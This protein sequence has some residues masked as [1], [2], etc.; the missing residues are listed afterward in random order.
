MD[1]YKDIGRDVGNTHLVLSAIRRYWETEASRGRDLIVAQQEDL[2]QLA[3]NS[4]GILETIQEVLDKH[5]SLGNRGRVRDKLKWTLASFVKDIG[6]QRQSLQENTHALAIFN[7]T[8]TAEN[9]SGVADQQIKV[10]EEHSQL[11]K[12]LVTRYFEYQTGVDNR[13]T[14]TFSQ[15]TVKDIQDDEDYSWQNLYPEFSAAGFDTTIVKRNRGFIREWITTVIPDENEKDTI[16]IAGSTIAE[17]DDDH[18]LA[19]I[20]DLTVSDGQKEVRVETKEPD[21]LRPPSRPTSASSRR[22]QSSTWHDE[23]DTKNPDYVAQMIAKVFKSKYGEDCDNLYQLPIKRAFH[24]LDW[25]GRGW[26]SIA[27]VQKYCHQAA[28]L[29]RFSLDTLDIGQL[30]KQMDVDD[31]NQ[32]SLDEFIEIVVTLRQLILESVIINNANFGGRIEAGLRLKTFFDTSVDES[33]LPFEW[34]HSRGPSSSRR[35][36]QHVFLH[37]DGKQAIAPL[38]TNF[39]NAAFIATGHCA[40]Q[41]SGALSKWRATV[42]SMPKE[43]A[44]EYTEALNSVLGAT[45][46]YHIFDAQY[47]PT[48]LHL[49]DYCL[50]R[51]SI[52]PPEQLQELGDCPVSDLMDLCRKCWEVLDPILGFVYDLKLDESKQTFIKTPSLE[53]V[54]LND[55]PLSLSEWRRLR[56]L[57]RSRRI[58]HDLP[59]WDEMKK[60][61]Q[62]CQEWCLSHSTHLDTQT[63]I[64]VKHSKDMFRSQQEAIEKAAVHRIKIEGVTLVSLKRDHFRP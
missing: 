60:T 31:D 5:R 64:A 27:E 51:L 11:L 33:M 29:A 40:S 10:L 13:L 43:Q 46:K 59:R 56:M 6:P 58:V 14:P 20:G 17:D 35:E 62:K 54:T 34:H 23:L 16:L 4:F 50:E 28:E 41:T 38:Q 47:L 21:V 26:I 3:G 7:A 48:K 36:Y 53:L 32:V 52:I 44:A 22:S 42:M 45:A 55:I 25:T 61:M 24:Y 19:G 8:L 18:A 63:Q 2:R 9:A 49:F 12:F 57:E 15:V 37:K 1:E 30:T 39:S